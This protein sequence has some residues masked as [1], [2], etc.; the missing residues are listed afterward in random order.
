MTFIR[1]YHRLVAGMDR[2]IG[3]IIE[4][5]DRSSLRDNTMIIILSDNGFML[6]EHG[7]VGKWLM[8]EESIRIP[9]I[10]QFPVSIRVPR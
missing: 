4:A 9:L 2:N 1:G 5:L 10:I 3:R 7:F 6:G 8:F